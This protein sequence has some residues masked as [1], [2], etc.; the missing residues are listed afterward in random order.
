MARIDPSIECTVGEEYEDEFGKMIKLTQSIAGIP[1]E[2]ADIRLNINK[3]GHTTING[4][5]FINPPELN[6]LLLEAEAA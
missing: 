4:E 2:C 6:E 1:I 5:Y 3:A